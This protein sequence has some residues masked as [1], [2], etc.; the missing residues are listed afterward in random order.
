M[1]PTRRA[2]GGGIGERQMRQGGDEAARAGGGGGAGVAVAGACVEAVEL[3]LERDQPVA[4]GA[5]G[6]GERRVG[7][8]RRCV[9]GGCRP[10]AAAMATGAG[11]AKP[12][13]AGGRRG[14]G[15]GGLARGIEPEEREREAVHVE[16]GHVGAGAEDEPDARAEVGA[17]D[18]VGEDAHLDRRDRAEVVEDERMVGAAGREGGGEAC[19]HGADDAGDLGERNL[20]DAGLAV[21]AEAELGLVVA[22]ARLGALAGDGAGGERDAE[23]ADVGGGGAGGGGDLGEGGALLGEVAGDLVDEEGAGDA[24]GLDEVGERDVVGDDDHLDGEA[25]GAG[26]LGGEAEVEAVAGVVLDDEQAPGGAGGGAD[27]GEDG[28][29]RGGGEDLAGDGGGEEALRRRSR[30]GR[31]RGRRRRR[32]RRRPSP[33]RGRRGGRP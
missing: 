18:L 8:G 9:A 12:V 26:A 15:E 29:D 14:G 24:A 17:Q 16:R 7:A 33:G 10:G 2:G 20:L 11:A 3:G 5:D 32:R 4:G 13:Q 1:S 28:G 22:H 6:G 31:A 23:R 27:A 21:D 30:R 19:G 25:L